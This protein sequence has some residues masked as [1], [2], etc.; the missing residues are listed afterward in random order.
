MGGETWFWKFQFSTGGSWDW[1][2]PAKEYVLTVNNGP[3]TFSY[4]GEDVDF[5]DTPLKKIKFSL[6]EGGAAGPVLEDVANIEQTIYT[7]E[8]GKLKKKEGK[9]NKLID[10]IYW[11]CESG[12]GEYSKVRLVSKWR[13][14]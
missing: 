5:K 14:G 8:A 13:T 1:F 3:L 4:Q 10:T 2:S 7:K 9:T 12:V 11:E 6:Y